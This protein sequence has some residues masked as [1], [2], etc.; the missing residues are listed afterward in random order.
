MTL[1]PN[2]SWTTKVQNS[3]NTFWRGY[4]LGHLKHWAHQYWQNYVS[5]WKIYCQLLVYVHFYREKKRHFLNCKVGQ[6]DEGHIVRGSAK[7]ITGSTKNLHLKKQ[8]VKFYNNLCDFVNL[9]VFYWKL[10]VS[11]GTE[12]QELGQFPYTVYPAGQ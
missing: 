12:T 9:F 10:L 5:N 6:C 8:M 2:L 3:N 7:N 11:A 1:T 4:F